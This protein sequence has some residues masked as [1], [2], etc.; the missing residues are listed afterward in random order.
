MLDGEPMAIG[1]IHFKISAK[2]S[3]EPIPVRSG[4]FRGAVGAVGEYRVEIYSFQKPSL[5]EADLA[6]LDPVGRAIAQ[7]QKN[8]VANGDRFSADVKAEG[9]NAYSFSVVSVKP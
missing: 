3:I 4:S 9:D 6:K 5:S 7:E 2:G 8:I 1:E